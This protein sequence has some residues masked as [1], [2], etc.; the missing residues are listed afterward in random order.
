[1]RGGKRRGRQN[2]EGNSMETNAA[3]DGMRKERLSDKGE[4]SSVV[5]LMK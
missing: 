4:E 5:E 1:M 3:S 2:N